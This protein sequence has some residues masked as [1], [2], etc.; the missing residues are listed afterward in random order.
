[1]K[2]NA[3]I[4]TVFVLFI[5]GA[6]PFGCATLNNKTD[7]SDVPAAD[8]DQIH[9]VTPEDT[10]R[11]LILGKVKV[12]SPSTGLS[13]DLQPFLGRWEGF[14]TN[15]P[16][17]NDLKVA[18][19][20]RSIKNNSGDGVIYYGYNLQY[21]TS[22]KSIHFKVSRKDEVLIEASLARISHTPI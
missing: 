17:K 16:A 2:K 21:P 12:E 6:I 3:A 5:A 10:N 13:K 1:M 22:I 20:V 11:F 9:A 15:P 19:V 4:L 14:N 18:L 7:P 8:F